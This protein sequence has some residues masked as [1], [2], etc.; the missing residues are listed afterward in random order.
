MEK[1]RLDVT[2]VGRWCSYYDQQRRSM[3]TETASFDSVLKLLS[4]WIKKN[5]KKEIISELI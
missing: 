3:N 4:N 1:L 5:E 2:H